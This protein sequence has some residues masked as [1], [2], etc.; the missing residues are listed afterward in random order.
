M[1]VVNLLAGVLGGVLVT[2]L[3]GVIFRR[4]TKAETADLITQAAER[5]LRQM[6]E[7]NDRLERD[8]SLLWTAVHQLAA[9][10]RA[11]GGDPDEIVGGINQRYTSEPRRPT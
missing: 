2:A 1:T 11:H 4:R 3:G 7:R 8:V 9:M 5:V 10:V 6:Q